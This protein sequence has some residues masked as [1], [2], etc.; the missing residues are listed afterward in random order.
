[1]GKITAAQ[2]AGSGGVAEAG[3]VYEIRRW[4]AR[5]RSVRFLRPNRRRRSLGQR[6]GPR[7][8][9][10]GGVRQSRSARHRAGARRGRASLRRGCAALRD[11]SSSARLHCFAQLVETGVRIQPRIRPEKAQLLARRLRSWIAGPTHRRNGRPPGPADIPLS[12]GGAELISVLTR[13]ASAKRVAGSASAAR[14]ATAS[15]FSRSDAER[16][17]AWLTISAIRPPPP[18]FSTSSRA[19]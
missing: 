9:C 6:A 4:V 19:R 13:F 15:V 5:C 1:M 12:V 7:A 17:V 10:G 18:L 11:L 14:L 2:D 16:V 3:R 8:T